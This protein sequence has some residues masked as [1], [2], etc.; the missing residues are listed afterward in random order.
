MVATTDWQQ[1]NQKYATLRRFKWLLRTWCLRLLRSASLCSQR[2]HPYGFSPV[3]TLMCCLRL[4]RSEKARWTCG[5]FP[6]W[7]L[8]CLRST[9]LRPK[10]LGQ[11]EHW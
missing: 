8:S 2:G 5:R 11:K 1:T 7:S 6:V 3:C 4:E 10:A 9:V